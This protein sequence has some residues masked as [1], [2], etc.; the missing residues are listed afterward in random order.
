MNK[1]LYHFTAKRFLESIKRQGLTRG[2]MLK[3][4]QPLQF[5]P[6]KQWLTTKKE[7]DQGWSIGTG[8]LSYKR[9]EVRLTVEIPIDAQGNLKPWTQ[10][11]FLV[12]LVANDLEDSDLADPE[13]WW[14][15]QG[16]IKPKWI[17][18]IKFNDN[19]V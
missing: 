6:N 5:L 8:R 13:N 11:R 3:S 12:P 2:M 18:E 19:R 9:N 15:Y 17:T 4:I 16:K 1:T 7:F 10:M 14:I